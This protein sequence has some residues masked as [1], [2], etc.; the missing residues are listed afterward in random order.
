MAQK[1]RIG[2]ILEHNREEMF[3]AYSARSEIPRSSNAKSF[4]LKIGHLKSAMLDPAVRQFSDD[5]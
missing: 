5:R 3:P 2:E 1:R 4:K